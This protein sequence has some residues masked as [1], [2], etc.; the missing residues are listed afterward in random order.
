MRK[1]SAPPGFTAHAQAPAHGRA[2]AKIRDA[3]KPRCTIMANFR[4]APP[5]S[6]PLAP[7]SVSFAVHASKTSMP[8][9]PLVSFTPQVPL[10]ND[11]Y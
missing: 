9:S 11:K 4:R 8:A 10:V 2:R 7:S 1:C 5:S 3:R 6:A